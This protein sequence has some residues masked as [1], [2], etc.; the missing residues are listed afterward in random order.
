MGERKVV[1]PSRATVASSDELIKA[2][3][4]IDSASG[5]VLI[6][7]SGLERA[8][9][10]GT[11]LLATAIVARESKGLGVT[12]IRPPKESGVAV[13]LEEIGFPHFGEI[14]GARPERKGD[15][16][17]MRQLTAMEPLYVHEV[18]NLVQRWVPGTPDTAA[19][20]I[21]LCFNELLQ[22]V[23]EHSDSPVGCFAHSRWFKQKE[24]VKIAVADAGIGIARSLKKN[25]RFARL[26][27]RALVRTAVLTEGA[28][29]RTSGGYGGYGLKHL[30]ALAIERSGRLTVVSGMVKL[31]VTRSGA[32]MF[33]S[34][35]LSGTVVEVEFPP[36]LHLAPSGRGVF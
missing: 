16:L 25:P 28:T 20:L 14:K 26:D 36:G 34:S 5:D 11:T 7:A 22:N 30:R 31:Q 24:N 3:A 4:Q 19:E 35:R 12:R 32:K 23:F 2:I 18:A 21:E 10:F 17:H 15:T 29:A 1:L 8:E 33:K 27:E 6:D 13:F 9:P